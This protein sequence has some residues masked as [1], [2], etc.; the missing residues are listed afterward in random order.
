ME[1]Y[2][3]KNVNVRAIDK[4]YIEETMLSKVFHS[5]FSVLIKS[6]VKSC[7]I[8]HKRLS[9]FFLHETE[10]SNLVKK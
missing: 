8:S 4:V 10:S 6:R 2:A 5:D 3:T 7:K 9:L 1:L